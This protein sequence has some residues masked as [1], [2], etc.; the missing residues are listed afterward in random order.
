MNRPILARDLD[1]KGLSSRRSSWTD[2]S[3]WQKYF[4]EYLRVTGYSVLLS[5]NLLQYTILFCA[6]EVYLKR[7]LEY[8]LRTIISAEWLHAHHYPFLFKLTC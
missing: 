4:C 6:D 7:S 3:D 1:Q 2:G 5:Q 8:R